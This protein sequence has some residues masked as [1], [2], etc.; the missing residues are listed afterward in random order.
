MEEDETIPEVSEKKSEADGEASDPLV[1]ANEGHSSFTL[2]KVDMVGEV[3]ECQTIAEASEISDIRGPPGAPEARRS[4]VVIQRSVAFD[5]A[6]ADEARE[7]SEAS[8]RT[9]WERGLRKT[10]SAGAAVKKEIVGIL[11]PPHPRKEL[12]SFPS[13]PECFLHELGVLE[14]IALEY[15][16]LLLS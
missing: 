5:L 12:K 1:T 11:K 10:D 9:P 15:V 4:G 3:G 8:E 6:E 2:E 14:T 7:A 13:L 16:L